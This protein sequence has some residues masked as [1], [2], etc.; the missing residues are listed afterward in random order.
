MSSTVVDSKTP[1]YSLFYRGDVLGARLQ[2]S[3]ETDD[4]HPCFKICGYDSSKLTNK[5]L[6]V[7]TGERQSHGLIFEERMC[8]YICKEM[9]EIEESRL[10]EK[11]TKQEKWDSYS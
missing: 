2:H 7:L 11:Y 10:M 5:K 9:I 8:V 1:E 4:P 3:P 6:E